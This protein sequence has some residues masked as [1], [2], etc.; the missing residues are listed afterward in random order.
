MFMLLFCLF[1]TDNVY[2]H[3]GYTVVQN[4]SPTTFYVHFLFLFELADVAIMNCQHC[5][6]VYCLQA[7]WFL[8]DMCLLFIVMIHPFIF[9]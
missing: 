9:N 3:F 7:M 1:N 4:C 5:G 6:E 8:G 2:V